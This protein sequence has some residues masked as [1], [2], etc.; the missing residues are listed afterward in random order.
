MNERHVVRF[1]CTAHRTV[2]EPGPT[3]AR[4]TVA[5]L[6]EA[7]SVKRY[8]SNS[9]WLQRLLLLRGNDIQAVDGVTLHIDPGEIVGLVGESGC[10]K[11]TLG[12]LLAGLVQPT[13]GSVS[14]RGRSLAS[15]DAETRKKVQLLFQY[16][17]ESLN[18]R[19]SV[20]TILGYPVRKMGYT[21]ETEITARVHS[22]LDVVG[23]PRRYTDRYSFQL[24]G[25]ELQRVALARTLALEPEFI[26]CD[27]PTSAVDMNVK[28]QILKLLA[29]ISR[30]KGISLLFISHDLSAV[31]FIADRI[32]VMYLG[33]VVEQAP[34]G[35]LFER[36]HHPYTKALLDA[37]ADIDPQA[38]R[39]ATLEGQPPSPVAPPSGCRF[40]P[41][42]AYQEQV[43]T[44]CMERGPELQPLSADHHVRCFLYP[45]NGQK[46]EFDQ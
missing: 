6:I 42:C 17:R 2:G 13:E 1:V 3:P 19:H 22:L 43:G 9:T 33:K 21:G 38:T 12:W 35:Q 25:G 14:F 20:G 46:V 39:R 37:I 36:P 11:T 41:R 18:P 15:I 5:A 27:E 24:S 28:V 23:L 40:H 34:A 4:I 29:D 16:P 45:E 44:L 32:C 30:E 31:R 8:Y 10:G 26:V 7:E